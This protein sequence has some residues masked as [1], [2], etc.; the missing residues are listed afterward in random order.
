MLSHR[1]EHAA[2]LLRLALGTIFIAHGLL[3]VLVFTIPGTVGFFQSVGLPG[4]LAYIVIA[5]ELL[6]GTALLLGFLTRWAALGLA[7]VAFGAIMPHAGNGWVF[8]SNGGGWEYPL[9][10]AI[11]CLVQAL[12]GAG[13]FGLDKH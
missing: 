10:L 11:A 1:P 12:L 3:K 4:F 7:I 2:T 6:G 8:S 9:F 13:R 5:A